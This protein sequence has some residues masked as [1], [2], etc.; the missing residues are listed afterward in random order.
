MTK[1]GQRHLLLFGMDQMIVREYLNTPVE[2][3][4]WGREDFVYHK[5]IEDNQIIIDTVKFLHVEMGKR[6]SQHYH[7]E[8]DEFFIPIK[9]RFEVKIWDKFSYTEQSFM[10]Y[11][12]D[13]MFVPKGTIHQI[14]GV[15]KENILLEI[16]SLDKPEDS[17][18]IRRGD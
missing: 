10:L 11:F 17:F 9:G 13:R 8:K 7:V 16:S 6:G 2:K 12:G 1:I 15:E 4:G 18:R 14:V 5:L 3:K